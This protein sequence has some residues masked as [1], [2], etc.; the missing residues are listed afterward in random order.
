MAGDTIDFG[1]VER[2]Q[3]DAVGVPGQ[4][5]FRLRARTATRSA[6]LWIEREQAQAI[7]QAL[8]QLLAQIQTQRGEPATVAD[9]GGPLDD[10]PMTPTV[11]FTVGRLG[12][13]HDDDHDLVV[14]QISNIEQSVEPESDLPSTEPA[15]VVAALVVRFTRPQAAA[16]RAQVEATL[17]AGRPRCPLCGVPMGANGEHLCIRANG[18][19]KDAIQGGEQQ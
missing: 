11:E 1:V 8:E 2:V 16:V 9:A 15:A 7:G 3:I 4:R 18:H 19:L 12:I 10:F 14:L 17:S 5:R 13:G 6:Q